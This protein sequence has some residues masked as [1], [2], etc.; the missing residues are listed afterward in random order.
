MKKIE[1]RVAVV[2]GAASGIG[3]ATAE[4]LARRGCRVALV[5]IAE[6]SLERAAAELRADGRTVSTHRVDVADREQMER[7][8]EAVIAEHERV[9][10][11]VNNAGV[12]LG[13]TLEELSWEDIDW[14]VGINFWGVVHG[15]KLFLPWLKRE[16]EG[17]IVNLS[18]MFGFAG[19]P[20]QGPYCA[21]KAA[22]RSLTE[23]LH[24]E[25]AGTKVGVTSVHPG[26]I[27]TN[28]ARN[29]RFY[30]DE[31]RARLVDFFEQR[32]TGPE[33]VAHR[34]VRAIERNRPRVVVTPEAHLLDWAKRVMPTGTQR[35]VRGLWSRGATR[36]NAG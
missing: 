32:G 5:D 33:K 16:D 35:L 7:L 26:G 12:A 18:S 22:V 11:V 13:Q 4:A 23:T 9:H 15:C 27:R 29:A 6:G 24:G 3:R 34:I 19:L 31:G 20:T 21:T 1:G 10:I 30:D 25:L 17:H 8:P 2:T 28:I 14:L 36:G